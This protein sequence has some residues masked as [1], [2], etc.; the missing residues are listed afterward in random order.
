M[1]YFC[2]VS[3]LNRSHEYDEDYFLARQ[4][5]REES[6]FHRNDEEENSLAMVKL[7]DQEEKEARRKKQLQLK[8]DQKV[9]LMLQ[10]QWIFEH[11]QQDSLKDDIELSSFISYNLLLKENQEQEESL[12]FAQQLQ[13][14]ENEYQTRQ[15]TKRENDDKRIAVKM[16]LRTSMIE[17]SSPVETIS[18]SSHATEISKTNKSG[19]KQYGSQC[20]LVSSQKDNE[21][22]ILR[23]RKEEKIKMMITQMFIEHAIFEYKTRQKTSRRKSMHRI[24]SPSTT[25]RSIFR[26]S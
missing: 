9:A 25:A 7:L 17:Q 20:H 15:S 8:E 4:L 16:I 2:Q 1:G 11:K 6:E 10:K 18:S 14:E 19:L 22:S 24:I 12:R 13:A 21:K 5:E 23:I 3:Q 26:K